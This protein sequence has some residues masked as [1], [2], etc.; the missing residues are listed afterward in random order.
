MTKRIRII[1]RGIGKTGAGILLTAL[2]LSLCPFLL[3]C[4]TTAGKA[5]TYKA[6]KASPVHNTKIE[7][8]T[9]KV[10]KAVHPKDGP[11]QR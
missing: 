10:D 8:A 3:G 4:G 11:L 9:K 2:V 5:A 6:K 7:K 1:Q